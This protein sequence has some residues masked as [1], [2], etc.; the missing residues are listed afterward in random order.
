MHELE[1]KLTPESDKHRPEWLESTPTWHSV[2]GVQLP[3]LRSATVDAALAEAQSHEGYSY[4][5]DL[6]EWLSLVALRSSRVQ[7]VD[8][9]DP[10]CCRY[11]VP[12][13]SDSRPFGTNGR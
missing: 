4:L 3:D 2:T 5:L 7:A 11:D 13:R 1:L 9:I 12:E 10:F 6:E 8:S